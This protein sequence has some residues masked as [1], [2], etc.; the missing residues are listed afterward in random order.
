[1]IK[2]EMITSND[3]QAF[4]DAVNKFLET[5]QVLEVQYEPIATVKQMGGM[6][7]TMVNNRAMIVYFTEGE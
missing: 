5:H 7:Y 3:I 6:S 1:M 4:E 2:I